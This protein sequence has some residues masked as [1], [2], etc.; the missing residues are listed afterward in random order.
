MGRRGPKPKPT[1]LKILTGN[2]GRKPLP[3]NEPQPEVGLPRCPKRFTGDAR[4]LWSTLAKQLTSCGIAT[5]L[6]ATALELLIDQYVNYTSASVQVLKTGPVWL[7]KGDGAIP[8]FAYSPYWVQ[9]QRAFKALLTILRDFGMTPSG[10]ASV[11]SA[12]PL[13]EY[14]DDPAAQYFA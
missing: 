6:D 8:K 7:E 9:Q 13:V 2:P 4:K 5:R 10:R 12:A 11:K 1:Q 14:K 3:Q